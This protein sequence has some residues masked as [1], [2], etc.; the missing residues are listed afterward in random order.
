MKA[1]RWGPWGRAAAAE[2]A[3][4]EE[5]EPPAPGPEA[6]EGGGARFP[7]PGCGATLA[8][9]PGERRLICGFCG[10][11]AAVPEAGRAARVEAVAEQDYEATLR[12]L[13]D[14]APIETTPTVPCG[15]CGASVE[16][17]P[18]ERA[19]VCPFC[20]S[21][22]VA[23]PAADAHIRP[24]ALLPFAMDAKAAQRAAATWI[25]GRWFA[26][27]GLKK[28]ARRRPLCGVYTPWWTFDARTESAYSGR[29]GDVYMVQRRGPKGQPVTET[30]IC[31]RRAAG[32]VR[33]DFDDVLALG[34]TALPEDCRRG[35][36]AWDLSRLEPYRRDFL[37]GFR[38]ETY[39]VGLEQGFTVAR[40][41]MDGVI[42]GDVRRDIGGD[43]QVIERLDTRVADVTFK[44]VLLPVWIGAY[45]WRGKS[46]RIVVNGR[47][48]AVWGER[49][50]SIWKIALA[51]L[52][53]L[54]AAGLAVWLSEGGGV[55]L[56]GFDP[57]RRAPSFD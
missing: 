29:R 53:A 30:R 11:E 56:D 55:S 43:R 16:F 5:G 44:H 39:T 2:P 50:W 32:R 8:F 23:E 33:R 54:A 47:S 6:G 31:W 38:A 52:A 45:R 48:G 37:A 35:L 27:N 41:V 26:P 51:V 22:L 25:A 21:P 20:A 18:S 14:A 46:Y 13:A 15:S 34:S 19:R 57:A 28:Y 7:C 49:P 17:D 42:R 12:R 36:G 1:P 4:V 9:K 3:P 40:G 24:Q 10:T